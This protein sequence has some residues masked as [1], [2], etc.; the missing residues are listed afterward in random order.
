[1]S[2]LLVV[3]HALAGSWHVVTCN[4][5]Y[6]SCLGKI[7][8]VV[9]CDLSCC[10]FPET[11]RAVKQPTNQ[12]T[13]I[14][15]HHLLASWP[16]LPLWKT[17]LWRTASLIPWLFPPSGRG[18]VVSIVSRWCTYC[19]LETSHGKITRHYSQYCSVAFCY[20]HK[21][22]RY[23]MCPGH[24]IKLHP[25]QVKLFWIGCVESGLVLAKTLT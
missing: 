12:P 8:E 23:Y 11:W 9:S 13:N 7:V 6:M 17:S 22:E 10:V 18:T 14:Q 3:C 25:H 5:L 4:V 16:L 20:V 2:S 1:M 24:D 15:R 21:C 19:L